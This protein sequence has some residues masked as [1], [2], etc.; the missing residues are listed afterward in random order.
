MPDIGTMERTEKKYLMSE[1]KYIA[2]L[3]RA[4]DR[5]VPDKYHDSH[6]FSC[7]L[8]TPDHLIIRNSLDA[9]AYKEKL[10]IRSYEAPRADTKVFFELKKKYKGIVYKRRES[11]TFGAAETYLSNGIRPVD[12]QIMREIDAAMKYSGMPQPSISLSYRRLSFVT[13]DDPFF[14]VTFDSDLVYGLKKGTFLTGVGVSV[15]DNDTRLME[16]KCLGGMPLWFSGLLSELEI[17]PTGFSKCR[18][19]YEKGILKQ[20]LIIQ[21]G[22]LLYA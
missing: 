19:A 9:E 18:T 22:E 2:L 7:Y 15:F 13:A 4:G 17:Y 5:L 20:N 3:R 11:M 16:V 14:R 8:D 6:I 12:S 21:K 10:R 1:D